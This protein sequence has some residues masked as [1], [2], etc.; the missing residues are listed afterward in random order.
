VLLSSAAQSWSATAPIF[1][2]SVP[3]ISS[4]TTPAPNIDARIWVN[5]ALFSVTSPSFSPIP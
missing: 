5:Q 3:F 4:P 2:N 1:I